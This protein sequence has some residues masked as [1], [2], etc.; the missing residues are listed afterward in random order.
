VL[1][2]ER[3]LV[4]LAPLAGPEPRTLGIGFALRAAQVGRQYTPVVFTE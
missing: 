4:G 1:L 2:H 3:R